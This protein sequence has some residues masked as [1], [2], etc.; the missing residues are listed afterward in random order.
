[1]DRATLGLVGAVSALALGGT[2]AIA[3]TVA[4][5]RS[6]AEMLAPIPNAVARLK[7]ADEARANDTTQNV[8]PTQDQD[9]AANRTGRCNPMSR[10]MPPVWCRQTRNETPPSPRQQDDQASSQG[11]ADRS[12]RTK[13][14]EPPAS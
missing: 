12:G 6:F 10:A 13:T 14:P 5:A 11:Q 8:Q 1:M 3:E 9:D 2:Q 7:A 4:P